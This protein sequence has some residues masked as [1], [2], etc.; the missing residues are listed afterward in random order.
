[1]KVGNEVILKNFIPAVRV[2]VA[3]QLATMHNFS[4]IEIADLLGITQAAVSKYLA[5][6]YSKTLK[7]LEETQRVKEISE[8]II[9]K[10][11]T[12]KKKEKVGHVC[13]VCKSYSGRCLYRH[14]ALELAEALK[15]E[16]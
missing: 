11:V 14:F 9:G 7:M 6:N 3:K 5:G 13:E 10:I 2:S 16:I 4:Q 1:M 15:E 12:E 8:Q